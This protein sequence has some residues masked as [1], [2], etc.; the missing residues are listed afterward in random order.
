MN[1]SELTDEVSKITRTEKSISKEIDFINVPL[2]I[3][4]DDNCGLPG[5][6]EAWLN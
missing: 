6:T 4:V 2:R 5:P 3:D 1:E